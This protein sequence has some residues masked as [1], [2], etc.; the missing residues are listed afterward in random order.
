MSP[1]QTFISHHAGPAAGI[2]AA[3]QIT[4]IGQ[5]GIWYWYTGERKIPPPAARL[6]AIW[7]AMSP[8]ERE[9]YFPTT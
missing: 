3:A 2:A 8:P 9:K 5:R 6:L 1:L 4:G 7:C